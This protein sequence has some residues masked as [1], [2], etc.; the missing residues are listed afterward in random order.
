MTPSLPRASEKA[1]SP[2]RLSLPYPPSVNGLTFNAKK[3]AGKGRVATEAYNAW[4]QAAGTR[5]KDSHRAGFGRYYLNIAVRRPDERRRDLGNL[6]KAISDLLVAH[7]VVQDDCLAERITL[8][9]DAGLAE[10]CV[11]IVGPAE[12]AMAA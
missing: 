7:G 5:V 4:K 2:V 6:E 9:W 12:E 10:E 8:Q 3:G 11:V 1:T